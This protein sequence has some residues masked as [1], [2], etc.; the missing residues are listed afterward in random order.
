MFEA[1]SGYKKLGKITRLY[2]G[3]SFLTVITLLIC[4]VALYLINSQNGV[5]SE[6][7]ITARASLGMGLLGG[8]ILTA[9]EKRTP[10]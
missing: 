4:A 1:K 10:D 3:I 6:L 9:T 7:L 2:I 8:L 5:S